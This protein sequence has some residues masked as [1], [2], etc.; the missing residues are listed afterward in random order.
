M[1]RAL[2][3]LR[4][5]RGSCP[6][7]LGHLPGSTLFSTLAR[8]GWGQVASGVT[9]PGGWGPSQTFSAAPPAQ[10]RAGGHLEQPENKAQRWP[11]TSPRSHS[12]AARSG[13]LQATVPARAPGHLLVLTAGLAFELPNLLGRR[14]GSAH[15]ARRGPGRPSQAGDCL[16]SA[17]LEPGGD[18]GTAARSRFRVGPERPLIAAGRQGGAVLAL[19]RF[20]TGRGGG[21]GEVRVRRTKRG[22]APAAA[23]RGGVR[24]SGIRIP[25]L[26]H[27]GPAVASP[28]GDRNRGESASECSRKAALPPGAGRSESLRWL[29]FCSGVEQVGPVGPGDPLSSELGG[30]D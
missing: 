9:L 10:R 8:V 25:L 18:A 20:T 15:G 22:H 21:N 4:G 19:A 3:A 24:D 14:V 6:H 12:A 28:P 2:S 16:C 23:P 17:P 1:R 5:C 13:G 30:P 29:Q 26:T 7:S 27:R 11:A